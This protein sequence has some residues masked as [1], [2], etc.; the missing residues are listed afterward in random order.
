MSTFRNLSTWLRV[1]ANAIALGLSLAPLIGLLIFVESYARN[2]PISEDWNELLD[3][4]FAVHNDSLDWNS[5]LGEYWGHRPIVTN[6]T[7]IILSY[8]TDWQIIIIPYLML[9]LAV[10]RFGLSVQIFREHLPAHTWLFLVP[11][12]LLIF[13]P[14]QHYVWLSGVFSVWHYVSLFTLAAVLV[15]TRYRVGWPALTAAAVLAVLAMYSQG[16]GVVTL[17]VLLLTLWMFGY[18]RWYHYTFWLAVMAV[19][20]FFYVQGSNVNVGGDTVGSNY[21]AVNF[22]RP[23]FFISFLIAFAGNPFALD[24]N[25]TISFFVGALALALFC[26]NMLVIV[27]RE[28]DWRNVA[29]WMTL[30]GFVLANGVLVYLTRYR[31][32]PERDYSI[33][34]TLQRYSLITGSLWTAVI[35]STLVTVQYLRKDHPYIGWIYVAGAA[36]LALLGG[37]Y[38]AGNI[39]AVQ[40]VAIE[41]DRPLGGDLPTAEEECVNW[42][43]LHRDYECLSTLSRFSDE[44]AIYKLAFY[45]LA[46]FHNQEAITVLP[47][48]YQPASPLVLDT[49]SPWMNAYLRRWYLGDMSEAAL[50]HVAPANESITDLKNPLDDWVY[51]YGG[52]SGDELAAFVH[53]APTVWYLR[54]REVPNNEA[55]FTAIMTELG[56][57]PTVI[58]STDSRYNTELTLIRFEQAPQMLDNPLEWDA[59]LRLMAWSARGEAV[60]DL[61]CQPI[62][63]QS[64]WTSED[65]LPNN[66]ALAVLLI[67]ADGTVISQSQSA[68]TPVP[69]PFWQ[70]EQLYLDERVFFVPCELPA[71]EYHLTLW[72][73][74]AGT[75]DPRLVD[76]SPSVSLRAWSLDD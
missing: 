57:L 2:V 54:T 4:A 69:S 33:Y 3:I 23:L 1:P 21:A 40:Q 10:I 16:A 30:A 45:G 8:A 20:L 61:I 71:G 7:T 27:R 53:D 35:G 26:G 22:H 64:W 52:S 24:G 66:Y 50:F 28:R 68:L 70:P 46:S 15:L 19:A 74:D 55:E 73:T 49:P 43:V 67:D 75:G 5:L 39:W 47:P 62:T 6:L 29:A 36:F 76:G 12:S 18:R 37:L 9:V 59:G 11:V 58:P 34:A 51:D 63:V 17:P 25:F 42:F 41:Y 44:D 56:Y 72:V 32:D 31:P 38:V 60:D 48:A 65:V 13:T 14:Y